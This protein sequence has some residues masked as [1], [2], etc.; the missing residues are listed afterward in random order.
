A[1]VIAASLVGFAIVMWISA[2]R[3]AEQR[4]LA[5]Q[6]KERAEQVAAFMIDIF[7]A[8]TP[9]KMQGREVTAKELLERG[10]QRIQSQLI[11]Q[12]ELRAQMLESIGYA[13]QLQGLP[14]R[15]IPLLGEALHLRLQISTKPTALLAT[16]MTNFATALYGAGRN[17]EAEGYFRQALAMNRKLF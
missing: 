5:T 17:A 10:A 4:D 1:T 6:A 15:A 16:C 14:D 2:H 11:Q 12:P 8:T 13:Y 9:D 7:S 3:T